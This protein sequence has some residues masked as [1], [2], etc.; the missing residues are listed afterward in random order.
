MMTVEFM[1]ISHNILSVRVSLSYLL[2][3]LMT[4]GKESGRV[5]SYSLSWLLVLVAVHSV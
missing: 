3:C 4:T 1:T 2:S 5:R